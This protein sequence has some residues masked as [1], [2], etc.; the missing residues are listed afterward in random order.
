MHHY[1]SPLDFSFDDLQIAHKNY[2]RL[3]RIFGDVPERPFSVAH[4]ASS[5][6]AQRMLDFVL[7]DL[8]TPGM[9]D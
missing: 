9:F 4:I 8:N 3:A 6:T 7:D 1:R 2:Q 5:D